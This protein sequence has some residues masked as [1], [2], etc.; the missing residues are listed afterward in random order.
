MIARMVEHWRTLLSSIALDPDQRIADLPLLSEGERQRMLVAWND[1][2]VDYPQEI[3]LHEPIEAQVER[4]PEATAVLYEQNQLTYRELNVRANQVANHL[5][6]E[7]RRV[8]KEC[9]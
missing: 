3:C 6:S 7:E 9:R 4:T 8:G 5:R 2:R 1:T